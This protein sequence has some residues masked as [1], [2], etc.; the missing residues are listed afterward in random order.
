M[1]A[2]NDVPEDALIFTPYLLGAVSD[3]ADGADALIGGVTPPD[4]GCKRSS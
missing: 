3:L 1:V 2:L 4:P